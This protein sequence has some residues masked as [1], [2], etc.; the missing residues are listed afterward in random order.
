MT[1]DVVVDGP[2]AWGRTVEHAPSYE[3]S[4]FGCRTG[5]RCEIE[6]LLWS[7]EGECLVFL[8]VE[9]PDDC[10]RIAA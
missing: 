1:K 6:M 7:M 4:S 10:E 8:C 2:G 5:V 9:Q 3:R